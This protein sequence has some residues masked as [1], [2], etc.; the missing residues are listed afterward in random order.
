MFKR[1]LDFIRGKR[2]K[3]EVSH[4][5]DG[6]GCPE[7]GNTRW[8]GIPDSLAIACT[9]CTATLIYDGKDKEGNQLYKSGVSLKDWAR[10][11]SER[12]WEQ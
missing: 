12:N 11:L 4:E 2:D 10:D 6:P 7:C 8:L 5:I 9:N 1:I 3:L